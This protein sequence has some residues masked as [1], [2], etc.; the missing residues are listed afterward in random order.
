MRGIQKIVV[1][2][3]LSLV[4]LVPLAPSASAATVLDTYCSPSGDYCT[5]IVKK[6]NGVISFRITAFA[7]Y[8]GEA[9]ACVRKETRVCNT[10]RPHRVEHGLFEWRIRWQG[11]YPN[12]GPGEYTV[13][14]RDGGTRIGH[15]LHFQRGA[16]T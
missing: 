8:F 9:T 16:V 12:Q 2:A 4:A 5:S 13:A 10:T 3:A 6:D 7:N 11:N 15:L 14:W 1:L